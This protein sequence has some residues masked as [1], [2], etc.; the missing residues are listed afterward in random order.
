MN[1]LGL[2]LPMS[3]LYIGWAL[4]ALDLHL[5]QIQS[6]QSQ[7]YIKLRADEDF[8]TNHELYGHMDGGSQAST[9]N[10]LEY[11]FHYQLLTGMPAT[12]KVADN[13]P[14]YP[15]CLGFLCITANTELG[16]SWLL[17]SIH[18]HCLLLSSHPVILDPSWAALHSQLL[19]IL[20]I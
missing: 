3:A 4:H 5:Q 11:L 9:T 17:L 10:H 19:L 1:F 16:L 20:P 6:L 18:Q 12:L 7:Y 8:T 15:I 14:N 13:T 2:P